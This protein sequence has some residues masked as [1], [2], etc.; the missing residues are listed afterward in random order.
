[1]FVNLQTD[2]ERRLCRS[3]T[4]PGRPMSTRK[5]ETKTTV[6]VSLLISWSSANSNSLLEVN[7][8]SMVDTRYKCD[9]TDSWCGVITVHTVD[10]AMYSSLSLGHLK[11]QA[12]RQSVD[13]WQVSLPLKC[14]WGVTM[15]WYAKRV[16]W[17]RALRG[18]WIQLVNQRSW[19]LH[20]SNF[21]DTP[22]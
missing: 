17:R 19:F 14:Q 15:S 5:R 11:R 16:K 4:C 8:Y 1:M 10:L 20:V 12:R 21:D 3:R 9:L 7:E 13:Y 18:T 6:R 22:W 2:F